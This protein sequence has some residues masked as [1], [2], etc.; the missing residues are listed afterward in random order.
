MKDWN[1]SRIIFFFAGLIPLAVLLFIGPSLDPKAYIDAIRILVTVLSILSGFLIATIIMIGDPNS[2]LPGSWRVASADKRER[3]RSLNRFAIL[4]YI[5]LTAILFAFCVSVLQ[6]ILPTCVYAWAIH[7]VLA[8][9]A[10]AL[11]WSFGLP[12]A[13]RREQMRRLDAEV[14]ARRHTKKQIDPPHPA[15]NYEE[16]KT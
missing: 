16:P 1:W 4:F 9:G 11:V 8:F 7:S 10:A 12:I 2:L 6:S 15:T 5:Y 14:D 3:R 13:I